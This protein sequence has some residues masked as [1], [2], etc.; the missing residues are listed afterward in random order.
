[1]SHYLSYLLLDV[2]RRIN[3]ALMAI[4]ATLILISSALIPINTVIL[5]IYPKNVA[6]IAFSSDFFRINVCLGAKKGVK[7]LYF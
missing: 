1:M 4:N 7:W 2:T 6:L 3:A 5:R